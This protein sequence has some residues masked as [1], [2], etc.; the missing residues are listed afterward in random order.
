M[1]ILFVSRAFPPVVGGIEQQNADLARFLGREC[2]LTL[3]ANRRGRLFLPI[4]APYALCFALWTAHRF[5][6]VLLGDGTLGLIGWL[7]KKLTRL[8]VVSVLHGIDVNYDS[9][10][11][12]VWYEKILV[13]IYKN[14]WVRRFLPALD[15][16][17]AVSQATKRSAIEHGLDGS[18]IFVIPNGIE[19]ARFRYARDRAKLSRLLGFDTTGSVV[20]LTVGRLV[21]RKGVA[22]F[23]RHV[24]PLLPT[25]FRYAVAGSGPEE[26]AI[27]DAIAASGTADRVVLLGRVSGPDKETLLGSADIFVQPNIPVPGDMEG[28]GIAVIE[29]SAAGLPV[30]ASRLE[31]LADAISDG[32][33]GTLVTPEDADGF[34]AA[35][36]ALR[37]N[38]VRTNASERGRT[39][40]RSHFDWPIIAVR[41]RDLLADFVKAVRDNH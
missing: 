30:V 15:G 4:F 16:Y 31:G 39:F 24:L 18:K 11:L 36:Q 28:F 9:K 14:F 7:L 17:I 23:I 37:D 25:E 35:I 6:I 12:G 8:T 21:K 20:L 10:S 27:Q 33:N 2:E 38:A 3:I 34:A 32:E 40:T 26:T 1:K 29:A 19:A 41:Y 22:W 13:E 5:D